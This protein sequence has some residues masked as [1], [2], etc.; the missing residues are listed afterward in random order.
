MMMYDQKQITVSPGAP[1]HNQPIEA[2]CPT[3]SWGLVPSADHYL[4]SVVAL[5]E[6]GSAR[7]DAPVIEKTLPGS[8]TS[9]TPALGEC[10]ERGGSYAWVITVPEP[11]S[12]DPVV[13]SSEPLFF[14]VASGAESGG[15]SGSLGA[16]AAAED[17]ALRT[18]LGPPAA[19]SQP[20]G[21]RLVAKGEGGPRSRGELSA[22]AGSSGPALSIDSGDDGIKVTAAGSGLDITSTSGNALQ[23]RSTSLAYAG[24]FLNDSDSE[25]GTQLSSGIFV[26]GNDNAAPDIILGGL[27]G[28]DDGRI[29]T[30][31]TQGG[32]DMFLIS[33][34]AVIVQLENDGVAADDDADFEIR[35]N[36][37]T[38]IF[39]VDDTDGVEITDDLVVQG[40]ATVNGT[41]SNPSDRARKENLEPIDPTEVLEQVAALPI[42]R[43][44][45]IRDAEDTPHLGPMAQDFFA[46]FGLGADER[47]IATVDADGVALAAIQGLYRLVELQRAE[48]NRLGAELEWLR[49]AA[50]VPDPPAHPR[51]RAPW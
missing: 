10:L 47:Y 2:R 30:D 27:A 1:D 26:S 5:D 32:S 38:V 50:G 37:G 33:N 13:A 22:G 14:A 12:G 15:E 34:D 16:A 39:R 49:Q 23:A 28:E 42:R 41:F 45:F 36:G 46:A 43:W 18:A 19:G 20:A 3:F 25:G 40:D 24:V 9:W 44:N 29:S 17:L 11:G 35:R 21:P 6:S 31:P 4:L 8:V 48:L 51:A 7:Q